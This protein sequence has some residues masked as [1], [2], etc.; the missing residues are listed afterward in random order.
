MRKT[1]PENRPAKEYQDFC[2]QAVCVSQLANWH[3]EVP[4]LQMSSKIVLESLFTEVSS[5]VHSKNKFA[6]LPNYLVT[7]IA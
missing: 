4:E 2:E 1:K 5:F 6:I 7:T 3:C